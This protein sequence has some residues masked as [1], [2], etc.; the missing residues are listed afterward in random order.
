M[1]LTIAALTTTLALSGAPAA[2]EA[3][4]VP[5]VRQAAAAD[6]TQYV[7]VGASFVVPGSGQL[8]QGDL[9]KGLA[10][11]GF[12]A[13]CL[14]LTQVGTGSQDQA[15]RVAGGVGLVGIGLWSPWDAF[16]KVSRP[17]QEVRP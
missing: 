16:S 15:L 1:P 10:H 8:I 2:F 5:E 4:P 3:A 14:G 9:L 7:P 11:L 6:W 17:A 13:A 12:A